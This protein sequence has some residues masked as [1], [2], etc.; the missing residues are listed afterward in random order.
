M[1]LTQ[2]PIHLSTLIP[3]I[4]LLSK[5]LIHTQSLSAVQKIESICKVISALQQRIIDLAQDKI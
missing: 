2:L 4:A 3:L 5:L 1:G